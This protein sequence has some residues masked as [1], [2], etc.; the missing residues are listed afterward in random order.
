MCFGL[1][2][3]SLKILP[4]NL[5][6]GNSFFSHKKKGFRLTFRC[7]SIDR[8]NAAALIFTIF[9]NADLL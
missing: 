7:V 8:G 2:P 6:F 4:L 3:L 1:W 9:F 5:K